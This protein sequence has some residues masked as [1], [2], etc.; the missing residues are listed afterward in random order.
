LAAGLAAGLALAI[1]FAAWAEDLALDLTAVLLWVFVFTFA[2][3]CALEMVLYFV[4]FFFAVAM[5]PS[6]SS[7]RRPGRPS[8]FEPAASLFRCLNSSDRSLVFRLPQH[9]RLKGGLERR[10]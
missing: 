2:F 8:P 9:L 7:P 6:S 10:S 4:D 1:G 3:F 5:T